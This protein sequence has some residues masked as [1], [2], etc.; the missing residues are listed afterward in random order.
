MLPSL[1]V[2][3]FREKPSAAV[4]PVIDRPP[5]EVREARVTPIKKVEH[6]EP[7]LKHNKSDKKTKK[8]NYP[9]K[10]NDFSNQTSCDDINYTSLKI[11]LDKL[12]VS[13]F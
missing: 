2:G 1:I 11:N 5:P 8:N 9:N 10:K 3:Y 4:A 7:P 12:K 13:F 6:I